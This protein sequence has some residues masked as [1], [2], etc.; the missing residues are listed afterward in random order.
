MDL[1]TKLAVVFTEP[2]LVSEVLELGLN[3]TFKPKAAVIMFEALHCLDSK[4]NL[5]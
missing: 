2:K 4:T 3:A 5:S 1:G